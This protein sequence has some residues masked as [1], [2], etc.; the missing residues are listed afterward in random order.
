MAVRSVGRTRRPVAEVGARLLGLAVVLGLVA[1]LAASAGARPPRTGVSDG[2]AAAGV[3]KCRHFRVVQIKHGHRVDVRVKKCVRVRSKACTV[4]WSKQKRHGKV[5][6]RKHN[7][8]WVA[9][10]SCPKAKKKTGGGTGPGGAGK[11]PLKVSS[12]GRFLETANN[13]PFLMVGD[14]PQSLIGMNSVASAT[15]YLADRAAH[16]FNTVWINLLCDTYTFCNADGKIYNNATG[17]YDN[18]APFTSGSSPSNYDLSTPNATYFA[19]AH[20]IIARAQADGIEVVLDPI[21]TGGWLGTLQNNG[22]GTTGA[23]T[24]PG[25]GT[26]DYCYGVYLGNYFKDLPNI[27]WMSGNDF[28]S[29]QTSADDAD[30]QEVAKGIQSVD[31]NHLQTSELAYCDTGGNSCIGYSSL[32]DTT[33]DWTGIFGLNAAYV[34]SPTYGEV[35]HAYNQS[36]TIPDFMVE[37][38]Y[39]GEQ[40]GGTDG[41]IVIRNCRLQEWWTMTSGATGQLYGS[42]NTDRIANGWSAADIDSPGVTQLRYQTNL[43]KTLAWYN[44]VPDQTHTLVTAGYGT[45]P[46]TGSIVSVTCVTDAETSDKTQALVYIPCS[47]VSAGA[48]SS[49]GS[50]QDITIDMS[51][52]AGTTT[53]KWYDPTNGN[54]TPVAGSPFTAA[55]HTIT[56]PSNNSAG[57]SDWV[58]LLDS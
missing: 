22:N 48:C 17:Q 45:C 34:Y 1:M 40:N 9:K 27:I 42:I 50:L 23:G 5:V 21:E 57:D 39:E 3:Q 25:T 14:S 15:S 24:C 29:F 7:P 53:A 2:A 35:L 52:M 37:A 46:T 31:T 12:N 54:F 20:A 13:Q 51:K 28:Q 33:H 8:V 47:R 30:V 26:K 49:S 41:C 11:F 43:L 18:L 10:V 58:L 6:I 55:S 32:D 44:L 56:E 16:G 36:P 19:Q 4:T 38:N